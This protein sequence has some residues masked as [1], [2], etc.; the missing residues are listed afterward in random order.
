MSPDMMVAA[1]D[2]E[3]RDT[4]SQ[5]MHFRDCIDVHIVLCIGDRRLSI[6]AMQHR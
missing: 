4:I 3:I 2:D 1:L 5:M 6:S